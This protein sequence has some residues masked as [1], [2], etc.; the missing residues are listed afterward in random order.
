MDNPGYVTL[1]RQ[2]GLLKE[3]QTVAQNI[4][5]AHTVGYRRE[6]VVFSEYITNMPE[7]G[8]SISM[9]TL[10]GRFLDTGQGAFS[11]T[12]GPLDLAL[13]GDGF[14]RIQTGDGERLTRAGAF[15]LDVEGQIVT[16]DGNP[17]LSAD[18]APIVLPLNAEKITISSDGGI[19]VDGEAAG[20]IGVVTADPQSLLRVGD[21]LFEAPNGTEPLENPKM[22]QGFLESSNVNT[23]WEI[24]RMIEVQRNYE[25]GKSLLDRE[26]DRLTKLIDTVRQG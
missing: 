23:V 16:A 5:N 4:A 19:D 20:S 18:G 22:A 6:G 25:L 10:R 12:G 24:T 26:H 21:T 15:G 8:D 17:V 9:A 1:S 7:Q 14:F 11:A 2:T 3:L 13:D